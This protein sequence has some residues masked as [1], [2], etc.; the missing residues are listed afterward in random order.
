M[1]GARMLA[2]TDD[3]VEIWRGMHC[4]YQDKYDAVAQ[5]TTPYGRR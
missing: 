1:R 2:V 4:I 3:R 5:P